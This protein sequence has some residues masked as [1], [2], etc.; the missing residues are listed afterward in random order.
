MQNAAEISD[1][2]Y[3]L[4]IAHDYDPISPREWERF[5]TMVCW[6]KRYSLGDEHDYKAPEDLY[7]SLIRGGGIDD[8]KIIDYVKNGNAENIKLAYNRSEREWELQ[9]HGD[10]TDRW[11]VERVYDPPLDAESGIVADD[12]LEYMGEEDLRHFAETAYM[13]EPLYLYDHSVQS[14]STRSFY[15]RAQHAEWDSGQ[16]GFV[17]VSYADIKERYGD[18][19]PKSIEKAYKT[20]KDEVENYDY[21]MRGECYGFKF[22]EN[23]EEKDSCWGFLGDFSAAIKAI[24]EHLPKDAKHLAENAEYGACKAAKPQKD[25]LGRIVKAKEKVQKAPATNKTRAKLRENLE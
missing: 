10:Y 6:H 5:G 9:V 21:Y 24:A 13:I 1:G 20:I 22:Y 8:G 3:K 12:I 15:G 2:R 14:I 18:V 19:S 16:V 7:R 25:L 4:E 11:Y 17:F 23:G